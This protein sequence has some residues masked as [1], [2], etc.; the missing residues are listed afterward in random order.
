MRRIGAALS[1]DTWD[2]ILFIA[3]PTDTFFLAEPR[4]SKYR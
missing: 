3:F 2:V 1:R 4:K